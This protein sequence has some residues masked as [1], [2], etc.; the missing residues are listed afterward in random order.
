MDTNSIEYEDRL[1]KMKD[2]LSRFSERVTKE[3]FYN[4]PIMRQTINSLSIGESPY[5]VIE[6][7]VDIIESQQ[8]TMYKL[9]QTSYPINLSHRV[10][11]ITNEDYNDFVHKNIG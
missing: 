8:E 7:L 9:Q 4:S 1:N 10:I 3:K 11:P 2:I 5:K 6:Q